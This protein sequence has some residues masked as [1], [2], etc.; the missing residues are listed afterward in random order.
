MSTRP[1]KASLPSLQECNTGREGPIDPWIATNTLQRSIAKTNQS[2]LPSTH[3]SSQ[4]W[5]RIY[6]ALIS[7]VCVL[8]SG[9]LSLGAIRLDSLSPYAEA[10]VHRMSVFSNYGATSLEVKATASFQS[11]GR[12]NEIQ[13]DKYS[14]VLRGQRIFLQCVFYQ[15]E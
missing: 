8:V 10:A 5:P 15:N 11:N 14:L 1:V 9:K 12:T 4:A 3:K 6:L 13:W 2:A 7:I